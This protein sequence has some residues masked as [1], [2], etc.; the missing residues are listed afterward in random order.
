MADRLIFD[1]CDSGFV[2]RSIDPSLINIE[3]EFE[4]V[5]SH[6]VSG[7]EFGK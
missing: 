6:Q 2:I 1:L 7:L 4:M 5:I 3:L